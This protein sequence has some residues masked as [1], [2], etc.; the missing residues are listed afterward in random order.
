MGW[1]NTGRGLDGMV[2]YR[3]E[4]GATLEDFH[5]E[6][7]RFLDAGAD[8]V[9]HLYRIVGRGAGSGVPVSQ[10]AAILAQLRNGKI[11][12][13]QVYLDHHQALEAAGLR[14]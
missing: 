12:K 14:E 6:N 9:I 3:E 11:L 5:T 1:C 2:Q 7:N 10:D 4:L 13:C 8:R